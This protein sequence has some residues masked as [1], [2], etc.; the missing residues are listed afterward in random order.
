MHPSD[1]MP[2]KVRKA[3]PKDFERLEEILSQNNMLTS[4]GIDGK[5]AMQRVYERMDK[6]FLVSEI[7]GYVVGMVRGCYDG[8]RAMIH[9]MAVDKKCQK[10]GIG[11]KMLYEI[12]SRF[13]SEGALSISITATKESKQYY[14]NLSFTDLP[15]TL[16]VAFDINDV[17]KKTKSYL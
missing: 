13:K 2:I 17:I 7:D 6:Y 12:A 14:K 4:P 15:I 16:M 10:Q 11:K 8:S 9:Q 5:E 1:N 3:E